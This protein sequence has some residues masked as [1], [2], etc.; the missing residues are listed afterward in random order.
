M[1]PGGITK[2]PRRPASRSATAMAAPFFAT[3][4]QPYVYQVRLS[5][6]I[7]CLTGFRLRI[8]FCSSSCLGSDADPKALSGILWILTVF[9]SFC[10]CW[11]G[12]LVSY[13]KSTPWDRQLSIYLLSIH[14]CIVYS[15]KIRAFS[16]N[17]NSCLFQLDMC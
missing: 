7:S 6:S 17:L 10:V 11:D 3:P 2:L 14:S 9:G 12:K 4:F 5:L 13:A 8:K 16:V 1:I 15:V